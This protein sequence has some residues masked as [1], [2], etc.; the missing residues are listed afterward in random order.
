MRIAP[1]AIAYARTLT[2]RPDRAEDVVQDV[3]LRLLDHQEYDLLRDGE[4]LLFTS[5]TNACINE[6]TRRREL[7]S[8]DEERAGGVALVDE[9]ASPQGVGPLDVAVSREL[10]AAVEAELKR[11]P[12]MQRAAVELKAMGRS[13]AEVAGMLQVSPG[14]AGVLIHRGRARLKEKLGPRLPGELR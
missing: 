9:L 8:L 14:N 1:R 6:A 4:K 11:L 13:L 2:G 5:I 3:F 7:R 10:V 12:A